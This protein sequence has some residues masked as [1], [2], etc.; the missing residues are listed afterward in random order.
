MESSCEKKVSI[1]TTEHFD[2]FTRDAVKLL[3]CLNSEITDFSLTSFIFH[4]V[5]ILVL[6]TSI[7]VQQPYL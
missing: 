3:K 6:T 1:L 7:K 4:G 5:E 2:S